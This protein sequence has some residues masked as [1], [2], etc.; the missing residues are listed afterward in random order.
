MQPLSTLSLLGMPMIATSRPCRALQMLA[1]ILTKD[2]HLWAISRRL[3]SYLV[4]L[5][6]SVEGTAVDPSICIP[7]YIYMYIY[8]RALLRL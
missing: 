5:L 1:D 8:E 4:G 3:V 6:G 2:G 7:V